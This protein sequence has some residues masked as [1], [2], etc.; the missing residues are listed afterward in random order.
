MTRDSN[1]PRFQNDPIPMT[2]FQN[3]PIPMND[4]TSSHDPIPQ[5]RVTLFTSFAG[6]CLRI[7]LIS[8]LL[9]SV[10]KKGSW[11]QDYNIISNSFTLIP[12]LGIPELKP[13]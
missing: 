3:E 5:R 10:L 1:D 13:F 11:T 7:L 6:E 8:V 12:K 2:R 9:I 4:G